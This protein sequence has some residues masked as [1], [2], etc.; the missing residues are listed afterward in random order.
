MPA[1]RW[2]EGADIAAAVSALARADLGF[3]TGTV[4]NADGGLTLARL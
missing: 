2:G 3:S 1:K 4:I